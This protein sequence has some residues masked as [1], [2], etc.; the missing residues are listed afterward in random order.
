MRR[1][2]AVLTA[3]AV[4]IAVGVLP[5][6]A[7]A[8]HPATSDSGTDVPWSNDMNQESF[9]EGYFGGPGLDVEC[10]QFLNHGGQIPASYEAAVVKSGSDW[11]RVYTDPPA[12]LLGPPNPNAQ[13]PNRRHEPPFSWVMKCD[14]EESEEQPIEQEV[15]AV[16]ECVVRQGVGLPLFTVEGRPGAE[17]IVNGVNVGGA[18]YGQPAQFGL[19]TWQAIALDGY[20][21]VGESS[22]EAVIEDCTPAATTTTTTT[23]P[24]TEVTEPTTPPPTQTVAAPPTTVEVT[25]PTA[26]P[27][28]LVELPFTGPD[29]RLIGVGFAALAL[30]ATLLLAARRRD[31]ETMG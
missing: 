13:H 16:F 12:Q 19:N 23:T 29:D 20:V 11:V 7:L 31:E 15:F 22:G 30:G 28:S 14:I 2:R 9:W 18:G 6:T 27:T 4:V 8:N 25:E 17:F 5:L 24:V 1:L 10:T 3:G 26:P 21:I